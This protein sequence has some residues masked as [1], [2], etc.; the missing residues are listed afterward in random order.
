MKLLLVR[1]GRSAHVHAGGLLDRSGVE[2]WRDAYDDAGIATD[3]R[4]PRALEEEVAASHGIV[5]SDL[6]R[7][8]ASAARLAAGREVTI[9]PLFRE[10]PLLIPRA[11]PFRAPLAAWEA[12]IHLRWGLDL[13]RR[14]GVARVAID[15]AHLAATWCRD[16]CRSCAPGDATIAVVTHGVFRRMLLEVLLANGWRCEPGRRSYAHW[17][18]WRLRAEASPPPRL[19]S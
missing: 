19:P 18:V 8:I 7:A 9:S 3:T 5:A 2:R 4:P 6:P 1:H 17:S 13:V 12:L 11:L 14:R 15:R 10:V 16:T